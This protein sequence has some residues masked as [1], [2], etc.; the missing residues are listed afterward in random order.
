MAHALGV[1]ATSFAASAALLGL[2]VLGALSVSVTLRH[3]SFPTPNP[4]DVVPYVPEELPPPPPIVRELPPQPDIE[5]LVVTEF[6]APP[7][8]PMQV[9][10]FLG[11]VTTSVGPAE[12]TNPRW[13]QRPRDLG[14]YYPRRAEERGVTGEVVL[15]CLVSTT[16]GLDC[17]VVSETP[18]NW[19]FAQAALRI[20][21]DHRMV[22]A[23]QDGTPVQGR[24]RMRVPFEVN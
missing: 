23:M 16:G 9:S 5:D 12:I 3:I 21:R 6:P 17:D 11:P 10:N 15:N 20:S 18:A 19:G 22:P 13:L 7:I 14:I 8:E 1:R 2:A 24:Y 4:V